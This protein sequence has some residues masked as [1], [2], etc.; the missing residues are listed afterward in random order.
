MRTIVTGGAGFIGRALAERLLNGAGPDD[1]IYLV[2]SLA[3]HGH[4]PELDGLLKD[5]RVRLI[6]VDLAAPSALKDCPTPVDR[7]YHLAAIVGVGPVLAAPQEVLRLNTL[8]TLAVFDWFV[9]N[10]RPG[11]RLLFAS[12]SE[13]YSGAAVAGLP[14]P[15][16]TPETVPVVIPDGASARISYALSKLWG[17]TYARCL[18]TSDGRLLASVRFHNVYGPGMGYDHV[19]PQV[20]MRIAAREDPFRMIGAEETRSFC[21]IGD[22][23]EATHQVME[24]PRLAPGIVVHVGAERAEVSM[25]ALYELLFELCGWRPRAR[26]EAAAA[27]G[28][29]ARRCPSIG[30]LRQ[31]TGYEPGTPLRDGLALTARW[32]LDHLPERSVTA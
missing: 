4:T 13:V 12:S 26:V 16:P 24:S 22:A 10:G 17:E 15:I 28:S 27:P 5:A 6:R 2:D 1:E 21:W 32:Y 30:R 31:L 25:A 29:V 23:V 11:S 7:L 18:S 9:G 14:L 3:R 20:V 8:T 19:I